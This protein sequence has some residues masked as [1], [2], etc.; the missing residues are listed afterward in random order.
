MP[1]L[2]LRRNEIVVGV[3]THKDEHVA[4]ALD[5]IG[6]SRGSYALPATPEGYAGLYA[7]AQAQGR[8]V[9][10]G[11]EG[12][13]SYGSG[14]ARFLRRH[15]ATVY[16][17]SRPPRRGERRASGKS[18]LVDAEH[19]AR[20]V[21]SGEAAAVPKATDGSVEVLRLIKIARDTAVKSRTQAMIALKSALVTAPDELRSELEGLSDFRLITACAA[22]SDELPAEPASA[23]RYVLRSLAIRW[24]ALHEEIKGH[25]RYLKQITEETAPQ[26]T[27]RFGIG[28]DCA[29]ELLVAAGDNSDRIRSEA[30]FAKL[31]GVCPIPASSGRTTGRHRLNRGGNRQAN[32]ALYRI[33]IVRLRWHP[34][35]IDY[36]ARRTAEGLTKK[37]IIRC[38]KRYVARE[39]YRLLPRSAKQDARDLANAA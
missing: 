7:W 8:V 9:A 15:G 17:V 31:C 25:A 6:G 29:A 32:A 37:E 5:G 26:L 10:F 21:L 19:A 3:D 33:V 14:L 28:F 23:V 34:P 24:L 1:S 22:L 38:L 11:V 30:A 2:D 18:D 4:V 27:A 35:T 13:G 16:E 39:V 20:Q 36:V 12:T